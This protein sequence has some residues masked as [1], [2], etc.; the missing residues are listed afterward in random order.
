MSCTRLAIDPEYNFGQLLLMKIWNWTSFNVA[1]VCF[2][3]L[4]SAFVCFCGLISNGNSIL[5]N[6]YLWKFEIGFIFGCFCL[7]LFAF[8]C[9]CLLLPAFAF[10]CF[11]L[12]L[13]FSPSVYN[14]RNSFFFFT[15]YFVNTRGLHVNL[16][17]DLLLA[18]QGRLN[19]LWEWVFDI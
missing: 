15:F 4:L 19:L 18:P 10:A 13:Q 7:L 6:F 8:A 3:L 11:C 5:N 12:L 17:L 14:R 1:F 9:F 2:C 16:T